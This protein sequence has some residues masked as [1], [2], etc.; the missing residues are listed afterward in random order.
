MTRRLHK[1][2]LCNPLK[3]TQPF[4]SNLNSIMVCQRDAGFFLA[5]KMQGNI[6]ENK[7]A[8]AVP[9]QV[10]SCSNNNHTL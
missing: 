7:G 9:G 10:V 6:C 8:I 1:D 3:M 5:L 4:L 2:S